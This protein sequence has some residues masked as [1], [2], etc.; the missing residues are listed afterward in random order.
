MTRNFFSI[1]KVNGCIIQLAT[2]VLLMACN[3]T[4]KTTSQTTTN[5]TVSK[6]PNILWLMAEDISP[7]LAA[8]G[9]STAITPNIDRLVPVSYT[10]LT[11]PTTERV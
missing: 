6:K 3:P 2:A 10:H 5:I 1:L 11:L 4:L 9:D 8:Y 7:F